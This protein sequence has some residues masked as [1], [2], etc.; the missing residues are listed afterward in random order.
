MGSSRMVQDAG[1]EVDGAGD[2]DALALAAG[3]GADAVQAVQGDA[4]GA[5]FLVGG[6][7]HPGDV[8]AADGPGSPASSEPRK[9]FRH[10]GISG[11]VARSW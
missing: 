8:E 11:T 3:K 4:Q 10:T 7:F 5:Q 6:P 2:G 1:A 9:K